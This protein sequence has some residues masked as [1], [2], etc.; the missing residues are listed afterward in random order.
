M[1][2]RQLQHRMVSLGRAYDL[3]AHGNPA[4]LNPTGTL[5]LGKPARV[6]PITTSI[7]RW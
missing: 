7:Q 3:Q 6:G 4:A 1:G 2:I 5:R